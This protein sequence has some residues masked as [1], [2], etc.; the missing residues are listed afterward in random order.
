MKEIIP[1]LGPVFA[2][3]FGLATVF[4]ERSPQTRWFAFAMVCAALAAALG[5]V[6]QQPSQLSLRI[7]LGATALICGISG[8][9]Q[10]ERSRSSAPEQSQVST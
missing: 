9:V 2:I 3:S 10:I 5:L 7:L 4:R 6:H 1:Y 8:G